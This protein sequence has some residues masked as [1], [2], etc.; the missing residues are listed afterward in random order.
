NASL[1]EAKRLNADVVILDTAGRLH[2]DVDLMSELKRLKAAV[3]ITETL[4]VA[5][6]MTGQ[7]AVK[8]GEVFGQ[9][10]GVDGVVLTKL[11]GD[12]RGGAALSFRVATGGRIRLAGP[13][14]EP[15]DLEGVHAERLPGPI[16][17]RR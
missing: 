12:A 8:V 13:G 15:A 7:E 2:I 16:P 4:L 1:A 11:D 14:A 5:D 3:P 17:G 6:S 9:E 10:V